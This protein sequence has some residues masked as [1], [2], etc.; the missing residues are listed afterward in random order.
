MVIKLVHGDH[1]NVM[2]YLEMKITGDIHVKIL[3][4]TEKFVSYNYGYK[5]I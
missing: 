3:L 4:M 5:Y 2:I 1:K